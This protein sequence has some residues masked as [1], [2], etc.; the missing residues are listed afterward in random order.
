MLYCH[1]HG[2]EL[3]FI[4]VL[5]ILYPVHFSCTLQVLSNGL[6][7]LRSLLPIFHPKTETGKFFETLWH[8]S[9]RRWTKSKTIVKLI[10]IGLLVGLP[11]KSFKAESLPNR[12]LIS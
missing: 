12:W 8:K 7:I 10:V 5:Y 2:T 9:Q 1:G 11:L 3:S 6:I 4:S